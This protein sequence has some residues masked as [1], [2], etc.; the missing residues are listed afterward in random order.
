MTDWLTPDEMR[1]WRAYILTSRQLYEALERDLVA[2]GLS[3]ADY[4]V[5]AYLSEAPGRR[6]RM[7]ELAQASL[8]SRSRL[9]HRMKVLEQAGIVRRESCLDD[10]RGSF[11]VLTDH[12]WQKIVA[13]APDHVLSVRSR[14]LDLLQS[15]EQALLAT[16]FER[17]G[18]KLREN[19]DVEFLEAKAE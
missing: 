16:I 4:E 3:M 14:F 1:A 18:E 2:H 12:G 13:A 10:R 9:S 6:V 15:D 8:L 11:A 5:I 7:S 17:F 19:A